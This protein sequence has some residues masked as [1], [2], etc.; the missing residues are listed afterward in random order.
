MSPRS[1]RKSDPAFSCDQLLSPLAL[2]VFDAAV[3]NGAQNAREW[4]QAAIGVKA[5][6]EIGIEETL[7]ALSKAR[8]N[9]GNPRQRSNVVSP[10]KFLRRT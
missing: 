2:M 4:L 8:D 1:F 10:S 5:D 7:P 3:N 9:R 6:G